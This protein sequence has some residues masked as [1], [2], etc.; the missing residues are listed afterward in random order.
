MVA[1]AIILAITAGLFL[2]EA[3]LKVWNWVMKDES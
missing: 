3:L 1:L 2:Q